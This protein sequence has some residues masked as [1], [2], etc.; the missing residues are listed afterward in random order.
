MKKRTVDRIIGVSAIV[1][2]TLTLIM[3]V[4]QTRIM[5]KQ[6][7]LSV[8]PRL[9]FGLDLTAVDTTLTYTRY[10]NNKGLGPAIINSSKI[11]QDDKEYE[12]DIETFVTTVFPELS[13]LGE[14]TSFS[15]LSDGHTLSAGE[16]RVLFS[17]RFSESSASSINE[18]L[19]IGIDEDL[20]FNLIVE[21]SSMYDEKWR[22]ESKT[23]G[24]PKRLN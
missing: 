13:N 2:S 14:F 9:A 17:Y 20:P 19:Q 5:H 21:Y 16:S 24:H 22:V 8:T 7:R 6:S 1:V 4:Y 15:S 23:D 11:V 3:F 10:V 12:M 18:Y